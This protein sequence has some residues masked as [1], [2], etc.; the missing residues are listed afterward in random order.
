MA[1]DM[2]EPQM[3]LCARVCVCVFVF[4]YHHGTNRYIG[5]RKCRQTAGKRPAVFTEGEGVYL[6]VEVSALG[7][8]M[9]E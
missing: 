7:L 8:C 5:G 4:V 6:G 9:G 1:E 3:P 2:V